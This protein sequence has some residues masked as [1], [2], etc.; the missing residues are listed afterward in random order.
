MSPCLPA[1]LSAIEG[2]S[3]VSLGFEPRVAYGAI[4]HSQS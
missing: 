1:P 3:L 4:S 2:C